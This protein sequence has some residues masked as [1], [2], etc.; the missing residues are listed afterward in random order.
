MK[1]LIKRKKEPEDR[2]QCGI[3]TCHAIVLLP[4]R[5]ITANCPHRDKQ[6][7]RCNG[8]LVLM[9]VTPEGKY[10]ALDN[11][12]QREMNR[13]YNQMKGVGKKNMKAPPDVR[14]LRLRDRGK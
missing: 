10:S 8:L 12:F 14:T 5:S 9:E 7:L 3:P 4:R 13:R 1:L 2:Y 11:M 6:G